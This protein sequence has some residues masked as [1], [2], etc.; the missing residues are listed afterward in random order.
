MMEEEGEGWEIKHTNQ[1][2]KWPSFRSQES[3]SPIFQEG[4]SSEEAKRVY[5]FGNIKDKSSGYNVFHCQ[6][7]QKSTPQNLRSLV[8]TDCENETFFYF[9]LLSLCHL[10]IS[11]W[12]LSTWKKLNWCWLN[13]PIQLFFFFFSEPYSFYLIISWTLLYVQI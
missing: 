1:G 6:D 10:M 5:Y 3:S 12:I 13:G 4:C 9:P 8:N 7:A 11:V 2:P